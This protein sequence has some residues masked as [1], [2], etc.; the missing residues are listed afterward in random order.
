VGT[1]YNSF[2]TNGEGFEDRLLDLLSAGGTRDFAD[3]LSPFGLDPKSP[4]FWKDA[5]NAH[6]GQLV[7]EAEK[8]A[9]ELG[10]VEKLLLEIW[11]IYP[12]KLR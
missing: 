5:I 3:A 10:Y 2:L 7:S 9:K 4:M 12:N 6:L 11:Y 1:L 8:I